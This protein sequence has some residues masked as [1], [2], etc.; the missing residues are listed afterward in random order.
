MLNVKKYLRFTNDQHLRLGQ[1]LLYVIKV[2]YLVVGDKTNPWILIRAGQPLQNSFH[3]VAH[4]TRFDIVV[5]HVDNKDV[6]RWRWEDVV[7]T[8]VASS[9]HFATAAT[10]GARR[11][12]VNQRGLLLAMLQACKRAN[13][14]AERN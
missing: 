8:E 2:H 12:H 6:S 13:D 11:T 10:N 7:A 5:R 1:C 14:K 3:V 9:N 4:K